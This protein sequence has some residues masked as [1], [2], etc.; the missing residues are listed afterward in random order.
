MIKDEIIKDIKIAESL[1]NRVKQRS[2]DCDPNIVYSLS[3]LQTI[4][5]RLFKIRDEIVKDR[6]LNY[7]FNEIIKDTETYRGNFTYNCSCKPKS[8]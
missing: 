4:T 7:R 3:E 2:Q 5:D 8:K 1:V 6:S